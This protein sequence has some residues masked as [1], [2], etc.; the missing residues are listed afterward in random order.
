MNQPAQDILDT[1]LG[2]LGFAAEVRE[3]KRDGDPILQIYSGERDLLI[4]RRGHTLDSLQYLVNRILQSRDPSAPRVQVDV[5]HYRQMCED[6][7]AQR[8]K[9]IA[10]I[11]RN[12]G[13][14]MQ[15]DPMN[16]YDRRIVHNI[17]KE[18]PDV[19]SWSPADDAK[20]KRI[21]LKRRR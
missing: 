1:I 3:V 18:D 8:V 9:Q 5:E 16:A 15:L 19:M 2:Y 13:H 7:L 6:A 12:T 21:T 10:D 11:V 4:G 14:P 17:V 20:I